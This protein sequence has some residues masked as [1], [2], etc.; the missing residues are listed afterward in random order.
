MKRK[1]KTGELVGKMN[2]KKEKKGAKNWIA[3]A[4]KN[5]GALHRQLG[6]KAGHKIPAGTLKRAADKGGV[7]GR[8]AR[9]AET[10][11]GLHHKDM[12]MKKTAKKAMPSAMK[13]CKTCGKKHMAGKCMKMKKGKK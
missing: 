2:A 7:L 4:V 8:R 5:P 11:K 3:G 9:L 12:A 13:M 6:V 10:L 1:F